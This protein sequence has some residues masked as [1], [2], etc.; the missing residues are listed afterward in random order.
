[1]TL[2]ALTANPY[3]TYRALRDQGVVWV[4]AV[5]RWLVSRWED[6]DAV[7][8]DA[9]RFT[10]R[11]HGSLQT[12]VMGR[13]MLRSDGAEHR[14]LRLAAQEPLSPRVVEQHWLPAFRRIADDLIDGFVDRDAADLITEFANPFAARCLG[15]VLGL[16]EATDD[17]L[18]TWSQAL[19]DGTANY[20]D[21]PDVWARTERAVAEV[22]AATA[23]ALRRVRSSADESIISAMAHAYADGEIE[24]LTDDEIC[25]NVKL[26]IGGGLN[27]PR[28]GIGIG[29]WALLTHED[30]R[31]RVAADPSL[32]PRATEEALRWISPLAMFPREVAQPVRIG[33]T[34]LQ[35]GARLGLV[36]ASANRDERHWDRPDEFDLDRPKTRNVAFGVGHHFCLGVW[37]SRHEIGGAALPALFDRLP[38]LRL[39]LDEPPEIRGWVFRGHTRLHVRWDPCAIRPQ[40]GTIRSVS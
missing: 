3:P 35:P 36:V 12:R 26:I 8:R 13:T 6:F 7:E 28:D 19:M 34:E 1:M 38:G 23:V 22:D 14:R 20:G 9:E 37:M 15:L 33:Q 25:S 2:E 39:D 30:Q 31:R 11:E 10:A 24:A 18:L 27:E 21:D 16:T 32:W 4:D 40:Y 17:E 29:A 5:N